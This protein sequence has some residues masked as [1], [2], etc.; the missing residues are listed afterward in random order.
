MLK[1]VTEFVGVYWTFHRTGTGV[2]FSQVVSDC[3]F[4]TANG[5]VNWNSFHAL[6]SK[7]VQG[8]LKI[9]MMRTLQIKF[10]SMSRNLL[11]LV[12]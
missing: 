2:V 9:S 1:V 12:N 7:A 8:A 6:I 4:S 10:V 3:L 11:Q 5:L